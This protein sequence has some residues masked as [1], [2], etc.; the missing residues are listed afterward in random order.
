M[1]T[2]CQLS[3]P[4]NSENASPFG[5]RTVYL[6]WP[7]SCA[8]VALLPRTA[9]AETASETTMITTART[10]FLFI[11][12]LLVV[13]RSPLRCSRTQ[14]QVSRIQMV[15]AQTTLIVTSMLPRVAWEYG[16]T[17]CAASTR[18]WA[19]WRSIPGRLTLRRAARPKTPCVV[20]RSTSASM[21]TSAGS[22]TFFLPA[23]SLIAERKHADQPAANSCSG[24]APAPG[25]PG[26]ESLTS[27]RPSSL[28]E[29][30]PSRPPV[31]CAFAVY[32]IFSRVTIRSLS[33]GWR[34]LRVH[35]DARRCA[36][37]ELRA[38]SFTPRNHLPTARGY[39]RFLKR[40][41]SSPA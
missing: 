9:S 23:T 33:R 41:I 19:A 40:L 35:L 15:P 32:R 28:W 8:E 5:T 34:T 11:A 1:E 18:A 26:D 20:P 36:G 3:Y 27:S 7:V 22:E 2:V 38:S 12:S 29:A 14:A 37:Y 24:L 25:P 31:V 6:A 16:H 10:L 17:W 13:G 21:A 39:R 30:P 4:L